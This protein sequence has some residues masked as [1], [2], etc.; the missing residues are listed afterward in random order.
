MGTG[1]HPA[2]F[3][4]NAFSMQK[5]G[6]CPANSIIFSHL[7]QISRFYMDVFQLDSSFTVPKLKFAGGIPF[8]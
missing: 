6:K 2:N 8:N 5:T 1:K 4:V 3:I 7:P